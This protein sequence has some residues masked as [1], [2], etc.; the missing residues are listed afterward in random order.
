MKEFINRCLLN[1]FV[2]SFGIFHQILTLVFRN[3]EKDY[4]LYFLDVI[5]ESNIK[6]FDN[7]SSDERT[8]L[9]FMKLNLK[10][11]TRVELEDKNTLILYFSDIWIKLNAAGNEYEFLQIGGNSQEK[12]EV[13]IVNSDGTFSIF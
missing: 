9:I 8:L 10:T 2:E 11:L 7:L 6:D 5:V 3:N 1:S 13:L 4:N 12:V